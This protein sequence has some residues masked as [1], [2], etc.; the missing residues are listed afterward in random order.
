MFVEMHIL[1]GA[2]SVHL[3]AAN[4]YL[5]EVVQ[6]DQPSI[7]SEVNCRCKHENSIIPEILKQ[8][9]HNI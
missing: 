7:T 8:F 5:R 4:K 2:V 6:L 9:F 1:F 3:S